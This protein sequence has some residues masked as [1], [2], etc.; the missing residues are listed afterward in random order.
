MLIYIV[1]QDVLGNIRWKEIMSHIVSAWA[2]TSSLR[3]LEQHCYRIA[4]KQFMLLITNIIAIFNIR[5]CTPNYP[6][7]HMK[8][9]IYVVLC[10]HHSTIYTKI[11]SPTV[12]TCLDDTSYS[13]SQPLRAF[14]KDDN[15]LYLFLSSDRVISLENIYIR[16]LEIRG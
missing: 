7:I 9:I 10:R 11:T 2:Y 8:L 4:S 13:S 12:S 14:S 15:F 16:W 6:I 3:W 5:S 1:Q